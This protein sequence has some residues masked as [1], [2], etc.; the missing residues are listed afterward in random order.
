MP[1]AYAFGARTFA[2]RSWACFLTASVSPKSW[3]RTACWLCANR[4]PDARTERNTVMYLVM[5]AFLLVMTR[6]PQCTPGPTRDEPMLRLR[7]LDG[8]YAL[9]RTPAYVQEPP[10]A[11]STRY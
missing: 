4:A 2:L 6:R 3:S 1:S 5:R 7:R 9:G 8:E 11:S 10:P